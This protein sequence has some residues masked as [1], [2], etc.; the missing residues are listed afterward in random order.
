MK[1]YIYITSLI[2]LFATITF[3]NALFIIPLC[4]SLVLL[5]LLSVKDVLFAKTQMNELTKKISEVS[6]VVNTIR[7]VNSQATRKQN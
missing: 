6:N 5:A 7:Y 1:Q 3:F 4:I 2:V